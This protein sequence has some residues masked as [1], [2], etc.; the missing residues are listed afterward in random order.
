MV[1]DHDRL[2][3]MVAGQSS[4]LAVWKGISGVSA[5]KGPDFTMGTASDVASFSSYI[6][7]NDDVLIACMQSGQIHLWTHASAL[8]GEALPTQT[9]GVG[10]SSNPP[11]KALLGPVSGRLYVLDN[12][13]ISIYATPTTVP[14]LV[15]K[16]KSGMSSPTDFA[17]LE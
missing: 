11:K 17:L 4:S 9:I 7:V 1:I 14:T 10:P 5:A 8:S 13:G 12:D 15:T 3:A 2:Y 6:A 16:I